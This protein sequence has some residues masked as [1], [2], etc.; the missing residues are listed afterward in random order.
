[1]ANRGDSGSPFLELPEGTVTLL[2]TD[3]EGSTKL[4][5]ELGAK[6]TSLLTDHHRILREI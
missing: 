6:Y 3:I 4:L 5:H 2:F 1:M